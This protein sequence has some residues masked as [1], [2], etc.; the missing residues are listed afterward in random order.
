VRRPRPRG[1]KQTTAIPSSRHVASRSVPVLFSISRTKGEYSVWRAAI[2]VILWA[3]RRVV[4]V[5]PDS[6]MCLIL[7]SLE[8]VVRNYPPVV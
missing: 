7:P 5:T 8:G 3:R 2:G 1:A 6:P 4:E